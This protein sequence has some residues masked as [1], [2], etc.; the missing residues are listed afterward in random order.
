MANRSTE[1]GDGMV[2]V[3]I[4]LRHD[5]LARLRAEQDRTGAPVAEQIRR[6][7]DATLGT[8]STRKGGRR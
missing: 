2:R 6:A 5:Q 7:I 1:T 4:F 3:S 8:K